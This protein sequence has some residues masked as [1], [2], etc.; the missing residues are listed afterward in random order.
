MI[1]FP[2]LK[3]VFLLLAFTP[4]TDGFSAFGTILKKSFNVVVELR[5]PFGPQPMKFLHDRVFPV[6]RV[7]N[8]D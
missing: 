7:V 6:I 4:F 1:Q 3:F 2:K 5:G 8:K